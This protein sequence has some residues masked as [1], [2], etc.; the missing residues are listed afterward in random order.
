MQVHL[1]DEEV[2][3]APAAATDPVEPEPAPDVPQASKFD[4]RA[5]GGGTPTS[6]DSEGEDPVYTIRGREVIDLREAE[7]REAEERVSVDLTDGGPDRPSETYYQRH[8]AHL[9]H[10]SDQEF[11]RPSPAK[12]HAKK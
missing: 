11:E 3:T 7:R 8:S 2:E 4:A 5:S 12:G 10:L 6:D 9:P 1:P